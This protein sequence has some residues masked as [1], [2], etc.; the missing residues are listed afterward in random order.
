M[1]NMIDVCSTS[2]SAI[3]GLALMYYKS[4]LPPPPQREVQ[5]TPPSPARSKF[6]LFSSPH[7]I[8]FKCL[9]SLLILLALP[10]F[11]AEIALASAESHFI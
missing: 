9:M 3:L 5:Q 11:V 7:L 10:F 1:T 8:Y 2:T 4:F 6:F